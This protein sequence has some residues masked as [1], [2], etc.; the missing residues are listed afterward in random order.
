MRSTASFPLRTFPLRTFV[1]ATLT[2]LGAC[3][4][5]DA[6]PSSSLNASNLGSGDVIHPTACVYGEPEVRVEGHKLIVTCPAG[7]QGATFE[8]Q[9]RASKPRVLDDGR[10]VVNCPDGSPTQ[11]PTPLPASKEAR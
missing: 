11:D 9:G 5:G 10:V 4:T 1:A 2:L 8:C 3:D 7:G 6:P